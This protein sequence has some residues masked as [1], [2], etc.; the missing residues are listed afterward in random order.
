MRGRKSLSLGESRKVHVCM[1][2]EL[3]VVYYCERSD[4]SEL[5]CIHRFD[6]EPGA[7]WRKVWTLRVVFFA[8]H[9]VYELYPF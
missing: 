4:V 3:P 8:I 7:F 5:T 2:A 9:L 1:Q 6:S